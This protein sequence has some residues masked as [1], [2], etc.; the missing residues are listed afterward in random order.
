MTAEFDRLEAKVIELE[1]ALSFQ[2]YTIEQLN[3]VIYRQQQTID[4]LE[5]KVNLV[6]EIVKKQDGYEQRSLQDEKPPHW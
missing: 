5:A 3:Q 2:D 4:D 1:S 6:A